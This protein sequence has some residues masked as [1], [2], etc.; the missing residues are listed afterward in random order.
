MKYL[1]APFGVLLISV[2]KGVLLISVQK[3][4]VAITRNGAGVSL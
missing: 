3:V 2:Q 1:G 4:T